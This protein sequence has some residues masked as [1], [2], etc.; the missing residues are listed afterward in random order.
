MRILNYG[1]LNLD[2][3]YKV[4]HIVQA[5]ETISSSGMDIYCG[6]KG[7]NQSISLA[8]A[9]SRVCHAG[10]IG[11]DGAPLLEVLR[12]N[13]VETESVREVGERTGN[14]IIQVSANGQNSI[15]LFGGANQE[16][17]KEYIDEALSRFGTRDLLLLQNEVNL[18]DYTIEKGAEK[19]MYIA[20]NPS[21]FDEKI[22]R[23]DLSKVSLLLIN[24]VEG[25]QMTSLREP[26]EILVSLR[27][28]YPVMD[29]VLTL[30]RNGALYSHGAGIAAHPIFDVPVVDTTAAGDAFTGYFITAINEGQSP[31]EAL[32]LAS[33]ASSLAVS[34]SGAA[35]S[36]PWRDEVDRAELS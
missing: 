12:E 34:R 26:M 24:E 5:G 13:G 25:E 35:V 10:M 19:G 2:Y 27:E 29:V 16:N 9:G 4:D 21:P 22:G 8:R 28:K 30:G 17:R 15:V 33:V 6:G 23:C 7:L 3:V 14:A 20:L 36:I 1:S 32:R 18:L 11:S 31:G